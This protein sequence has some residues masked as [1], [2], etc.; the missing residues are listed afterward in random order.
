M[1]AVQLVLIL[2]LQSPAH[3]SS[4]WDGPKANLTFSR[5]P[6]VSVL[7]FLRDLFDH[8]RNRRNRDQQD[9][10]EPRRNTANEDKGTEKGAERVD[11]N[12]SVNLKPFDD[13]DCRRVTNARGEPYKVMVP[14]SDKEEWKSMQENP[15]QD[16]TFADC[17]APTPTPPSGICG[18]GLSFNE[19]T[20][21]VSAAVGA[22]NDPQTVATGQFPIPGYWPPYHADQV[23]LNRICTI[24]KCGPGTL[25]SSTRF[26]NPRDDALLR[27]DGSAWVKF[28]ARQSNIKLNHRS[29]V[30]MSC[31]MP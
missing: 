23:T 21:Y 8:S 3:A 22:S 31:A 10:Q 30:T 17:P 13:M 24:L 15:P 20:A 9:R 5:R 6:A 12:T 1:M 29:A 16:V 18:R 14:V 28:P 27:W 11:K 4:F 7:G 25:L 19:V 2:A 26:N